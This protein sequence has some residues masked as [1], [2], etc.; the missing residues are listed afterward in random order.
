[1]EQLT[2]LLFLK[3]ADEQAQASPIGKNV[4]PNDYN[5]QSLV[6]RDN[7]NDLHTHYGSILKR[8]ATSDGM[9]GVIFHNARNKIRDPE[10]LKRLVVDLIDKRNWSALDT[11]VKGDAYEGLLEKNAQDTK[12]GAGQYF[13]PRPV[14]RAMVQCI[15][16][17]LGETIYDP[18]CGTGGFLL[19]THEYILEQNPN[20]TDQQK[21]QLRLETFHG[22]EL[23][24]EVTR[25][26][27]MNLLLHGIG[28]ATD[29]EGEV[30]IITHDSLSED[31][32]RRYDVVLTNPPFGKKSSMITISEQ[33]T[34]EKPP[35]SVLRPDFWVS[36]SNKQLNF[37]QHINTT[38]NETGRAAVV[39]PDNV[40]FEGGQGETIRRRLLNE[41]DVHTLLRLPP[42]IF[43]AQGIKTNVLFFERRPLSEKPSTEELW[44]YDLRTNMH[45]TL[46]TK[47][48][49][50]S[51]LTDFIKCYSPEDRS[52]RKPTWSNKTPDGRWR[53][54]S[55]DELYSRDK[56]NLDIFW[57]DDET[58][59]SL[60]STDNP[61]DIAAEI[62]EDLQ[63][64]I[65]QL[66][67]ITTDLN[68]VR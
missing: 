14:I 5:W 62:L 15:R 38:L 52:K 51:D 23:V 67:E 57:L 44:V 31:L 54:F 18:A 50:M 47:R 45:F 10:K 4:I 27:A 28:P 33:G 43:Y 21:K 34:R 48:L 39:V 29:K 32:G 66:S 58:Q 12:S 41:Y 61:N 63:A 56:L 11:D 13:T 42:G 55:F 60:D 9:L 16:P 26:G 65:L 17:Q 2:Y 40:L 20:L 53:A 19:A 25:L 68:D 8:L 30:P 59:E 35:L 46:R 49:E 64:A 1:V 37:L 6:R 22:V 24:D 3:M 7:A 36:T